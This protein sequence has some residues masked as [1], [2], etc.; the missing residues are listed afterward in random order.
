MQP[1]PL[2]SH[3]YLRECFDY[4]TETGELRWRTRPRAHFSRPNVHAA[5]N[6]SCAGRLFGKV[7]SDGNGRSGELNGVDYK[8]HRLIFKLV[9]GVD[10]IE[11]DHRDRDRLNN[12][13][14]NLRNATQG[15]NNANVGARR[16]NRVGLKGVKPHGLRFVARITADR[17]TVHLGTFPTAEAAH[18]AYVE[19][20]RARWGEF[21][22]SE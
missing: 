10:P 3:Q 14:S 8:A 1:R 12:R 5:F 16:H 7:T 6:A 20:A 21:A 17:R 22:A 11:V 15:Q 19:A 2:P 9:T 4:D 13:W 18:A